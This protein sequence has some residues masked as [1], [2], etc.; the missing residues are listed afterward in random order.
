MIWKRKWSLNLSLFRSTWTLRYHQR[1]YKMIMILSH[2][3]HTSEDMAMSIHQNK[4]NLASR[5]KGLRSLF[6]KETFQYLKLDPFIQEMILCINIFIII[7]KL[8]KRGKFYLYWLITLVNLKF[9]FSLII[10]QTYQPL[11][12]QVFPML[13]RW[14][15]IDSECK[16]D[17]RTSSNIVSVV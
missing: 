12:N 6:T 8:P 4:N 10:H 3:H 14:F 16:W 5:I 2:S 1:L 7:Q 11:R 13:I 17:T 9:L 15:W